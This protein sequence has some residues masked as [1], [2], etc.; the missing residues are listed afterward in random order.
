MKGRRSVPGR[1][2]CSK[3]WWTCHSCPSKRW[4][5]TTWGKAIDAVSSKRVATLMCWDS[6]LH[7]DLGVVDEIL[8]RDH[9][10]GSPHWCWPTGCWRSRRIFLSL[11]RWWSEAL[12]SRYTITA[13][14]L[15]P[16]PTPALILTMKWLPQAFPSL[17][18]KLNLTTSGATDVS[19]VPWRFALSQR[20]LRIRR[21]PCKWW[22]DVDGQ[23]DGGRA[24]NH[25][26]VCVL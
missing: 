22:A 4:R 11:V 15:G 2:P 9:G 6:R 3:C 16:P 26:N 12:Y 8:Q 7:V 5:R 20:W 18:G 1:E 25:S 23:V 21:L 14:L 24:A 10:T 13:N 17:M 19:S